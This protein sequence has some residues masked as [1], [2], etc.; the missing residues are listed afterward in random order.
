MICN[1][2]C[3]DLSCV[4]TFFETDVLFTSILFN[5]YFNVICNEAYKYMY[6]VI[7]FFETDV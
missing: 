4:I 2:G 6:C 1:E 5:M 3:K 7:T